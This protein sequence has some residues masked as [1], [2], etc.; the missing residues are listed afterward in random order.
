MITEAVTGTGAFLR[1]ALR[2][3]PGIIAIFAQGLTD[4]PYGYSDVPPELI[5]TNCLG[6]FA[7][8]Y[9]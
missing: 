3:F 6:P 7:V 5:R 4:L 8:F 1:L 9:G 2:D